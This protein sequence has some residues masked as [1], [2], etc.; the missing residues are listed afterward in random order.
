MS[1]LAL[2]LL[3]VWTMWKCKRW[4]FYLEEQC[5]GTSL[6][7]MGRCHGRDRGTNMLL[8]SQLPTRTELLPRL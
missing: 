8:P 4:G 5:I 3:G 1:I 6:L 2:G 7:E